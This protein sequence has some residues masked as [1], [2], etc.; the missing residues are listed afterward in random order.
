MT[1]STSH[2]T[3]ISRKS[4]VD[5]HLPAVLMNRYITIQMMATN[6]MVLKTCP[7]YSPSRGRMNSSRNAPFRMAAIRRM[8]HTPI[9]YKKSFFTIVTVNVYHIYLYLALQKHSF[10]KIVIHASQAL[11]IVFISVT[12]K[13]NFAFPFQ[14]SPLSA[15]RQLTRQS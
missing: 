13:H 2:N 6:M 10:V 7:G 3:P 11:V 12:C 1:V 8:N 15:G 9:A 4:I 14:S 5:A